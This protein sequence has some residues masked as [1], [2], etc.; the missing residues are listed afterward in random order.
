[1]S[2]AWANGLQDV[3]RFSQV[4]ESSLTFQLGGSPYR[5][6]GTP[7]ADLDRTSLAGTMTSPRDNSRPG[8]RHCERSAA[9]QRGRQPTPATR[10][11]TPLTQPNNLAMTVVSESVIAS[12]ARQ[13]RRTTAPARDTPSHSAFPRTATQP[14]PHRDR[15]SPV[16]PSTPGEQE[17]KATAQGVRPNARPT[18]CG[19]LASQAQRNPAQP[20]GGQLAPSHGPHPPRPS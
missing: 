8:I 19:P 4:A 11:A 12:A 15:P 9:I 2:T 16:L 7:Q 13:S 5:R 1:M 6:P 20:P 10:P 3:G 18:R 17:A 14:N